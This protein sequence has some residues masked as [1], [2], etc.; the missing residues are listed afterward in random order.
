[1]LND[2]HP[3][4]LIITFYVSYFS[5]RKIA[6][7]VVKV[8]QYRD[9]REA[10][11]DVTIISAGASELATHSKAQ[12]VIHNIQKKRKRI[13]NQRLVKSCHYHH[14]DFLGRKRRSSKRHTYMGQKRWC[15]GTDK[16]KR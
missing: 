6:D 8:H 1:M 4:R 12:Q 5:D 7:H 16:I 15:Y 14:L 10:D 9:P 2:F 13:Q 3:I 11:G